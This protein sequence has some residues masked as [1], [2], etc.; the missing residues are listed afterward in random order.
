MDLADAEAIEA[1]CF[2]DTVWPA[3]RQ[4]LDLH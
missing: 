2:H 4:A 3:G 1:C